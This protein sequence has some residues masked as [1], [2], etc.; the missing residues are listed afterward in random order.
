MQRL[1]GSAKPPRERAGAKRR[2]LDGL[3]SGRH[4]YS[5]DSGFFGL[6]SNCT[7]LYRDVTNQTNCT[8]RDE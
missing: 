1:S 4:V 6:N 5:L 2:S 8:G 3:E 7:P